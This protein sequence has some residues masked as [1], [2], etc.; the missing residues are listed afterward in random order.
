MSRG[1]QT[2]TLR[3]NPARHDDQLDDQGDYDV[4]LTDDCGNF[5]SEV[6]HVI[7]PPVGDTNCDGGVNFA[8]INPFVLMLS[9]PNGYQQQYPYCRLIQGDCNGDGRVD[10]G[11][12]N[13][14]VAPAVWRV[15]VAGT[16]SGGLSA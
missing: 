7:V 16:G 13:P 2:A 9:D 15:R 14:F 10:F 4:W 5:V 1:T 11:D 3:I 6:A 12:I 8:D